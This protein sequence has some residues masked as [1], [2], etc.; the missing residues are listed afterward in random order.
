MCTLIPCSVK[1]GGVIQSP[2]SVVSACILQT[3]GLVIV[4]HKLQIIH[5]V[6]CEFSSM[7]DKFHS[8]SSI[9]V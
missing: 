6:V 2:N 1:A 4:A 9:A 8:E 5:A 7:G 3:V